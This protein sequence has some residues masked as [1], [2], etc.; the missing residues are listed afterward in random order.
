M[1]NFNLFEKII[2]DCKDLTPEEIMPFLNGEPFLDPDLACRIRLINEELPNVKVSLYTNAFA[3]NKTKIEELEGLKINYFNFSLNATTNHDR[4]NIMGIPLDKTIEN[5]KLL[6]EAFPK[7]HMTG[8]ILIDRGYSTI[9]ALNEFNDL[10]VGIGIVPIRFLSS[11]F[12]GNLREAYNKDTF[13]PRLDGH[14]TILSTGEVNLCCMDTF[15]EKIL[16]DIKVNSLREIW[17]SKEFLTYYKLNLAER[18]NDIWPCD[19]C[20]GV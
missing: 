19:Q 15:G 9:K 5:I 13:C 17:E 18:K 20:T 3:L 8:S 7:A 11:N 16:G 10:C 4:K 6:R 2:E 14:M 12:M 1:I